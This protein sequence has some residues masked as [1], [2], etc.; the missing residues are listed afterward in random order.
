MILATLQLM[1]FYA[2]DQDMYRIERYMRAI[3]YGLLP[4][5]VF[6]GWLE[7]NTWN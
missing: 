4:L 3:L 1:S 7:N 2:V 5:N 6:V